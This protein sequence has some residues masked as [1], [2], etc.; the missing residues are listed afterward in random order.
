MG[1]F[2]AADRCVV[3]LGRNRKGVGVKRVEFYYDLVSLYSYLAHHR[4]GRICEEHGVE[5]VLRPMLLGAVHKAVGLQAP[6]QIEPKRR[7]K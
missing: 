6:V 5:L 4:I 2:R 3:Y 7:Y 1:I